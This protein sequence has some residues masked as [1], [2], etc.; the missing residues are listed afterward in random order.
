LTD[1]VIESDSSSELKLAGLISSI[2]V[3]D[4]HNITAT[5]DGRITVNFSDLKD[6]DYRLTFLKSIYL[7]QFKKTDKGLLEFNEDGEYTFRPKK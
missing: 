5:F 7:T 1:T 2:D 3:S 6:L 4:S